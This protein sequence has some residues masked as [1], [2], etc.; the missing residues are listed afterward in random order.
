MKKQIF[1]FAIACILTVFLLV[2]CSGES[3]ADPD[4]P[5][6]IPGDGTSERPGGDTDSDAPTNEVLVT[7][8]SE[9]AQVKDR[10]VNDFDY[11]SLFSILADNENVPVEASYLDLTKLKTSPGSYPVTC[12]YCDKQAT[13]MI[14]VLKTDYRVSLSRE[15]VSVKLS[16]AQDF[17]YPAL[18]SVTMDGEPVSVTSDMVETDFTPAEGTYTYTVTYG[19]ASATLTVRVTPDHL[20]E[21]MTSYRNLTLTVADLLTYDYTDLFSLYRDGMPIEV[22]ADM[23][24]TSALTGE[25]A[26]P[27]VGQTYPVILHYTYG[28]SSCTQTARVTVAAEEETVVTTKNVVIYP[29]SQV[30]DLTT[31]FRITRGDTELP[32]D[33]ENITGTIDYTKGGTY[34]ISLSYEGTDY[35]ATV[36]VRDG[37]V[38]QYAV[39]D[40]VKVKKGTN[41]AT[42]PFDGDFVVI[43]NG[44]RFY[45]IPPSYFDLTEVD[46]TR[47][48]TY[49]ATLSIPYNET[50]SSGI[51]PSVTFTYYTATIH[52]QVVENNYSIA[53]GAEELLLPKGTTSYNVFGNLKV[54]I[55]GRNQTLTGNPAYVDSISCYAEV[56]SDPIDFESLAVQTVRIAVYVD[57]PD[58]DPVVVTYPLRIDSDIRVSAAGAAVFAGSAFY[59]KDLFTITR[60]DEPVEV[61]YDM[62]SGKVDIFTPGVYTVTLEFEGI[63]REAQVVVFDKALIGT[64]HTSL[65]TIAESAADDEEQPS[66]ALPLGD[67]V[68]RADGT[69]T[70]NGSD[71]VITGGIDSTTMTLSY[72][73]YAYTLYFSDGIAVLDP[74][75]SLKLGYNDWKRPMIYFHEDVWEPE[76]K[77]TVNYSSSHVLELNCITYSID[78][79]HI[80][81]TTGEREMWYALKIALVEKTSADTVYKVTWGEASY[82]DGFVPG[83]DVISVLTFD[84]LT[85]GFT[86]SS[87]TVGKVNP[88]DGERLWTNRVFTGTLNGKPAELR[89]D[90]YEHFTFLVDGVTVC[91]VNPTFS[92]DGYAVLDYRNE[93]AL[94]YDMTGDTYEPYAYFFRLNTEENTFTVVEKDLYFGKYICENMYLFLDGYGTG[95]INF[96]TRSY[97]TTSISYRVVDGVLTVRY[98][99]TNPG[100]A[101]GESSSYYI[102]P[103]LN[104]LTVRDFEGADMVGRQF[105]N[106]VIT[107]G[108]IVEIS[109]FSLGQATSE[110]AGLEQLLSRITITTKD[111][112]LNDAAKKACINKK[113]VLFTRAGYYLYTITL[114]VGGKDVVSRYALQVLPA[115]YAG[116]PLAVNWGVGLLGSGNALVIDACGKV[117][118]AVGDS[119]YTGLARLNEDSFT[120]QLFSETHSRLTLQGSLLAEGILQVRGSGDMNFSN[121]FTTGTAKSTGTAGTVLRAITVNG[122]TKYYLS[123]SVSSFGTAVT[124]ECLNGSDPGATGAILCLTDADRHQTC[125]KVNAW[126]NTSEGLTLADA[127]R[128]TYIAEGA[129]DLIL[130]GFGGAVY[131]GGAATYR[132]NG[133]VATVTLSQSDV[134][135]FRLNTADAGYEALEIPVGNALLEGKTFTATYQF[136]CGYY[137]Y[138]A[139]TSFAFGKNGVVTVT[140]VSDQHDNG[141]DRCEDDL[142]APTFATNA[143]TNGTYTVSGDHVTVTV[144]GET[145]VFLISNLQICNQIVCESTTVSSDAH[146]YFKTG[147]AFNQPV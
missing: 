12:T 110:T 93:T 64:Y 71:A 107:D 65:T 102:P 15:E 91:Y 143:G 10:Q 94:L 108:A 142:Y 7:A 38:L 141:D 104:V 28:T 111:G 50:A 125:L 144:G 18:F 76:E 117:T 5:A 27:T 9:S 129:P 37:V 105:V 116:H 55:N 72:G 119:H 57:G 35:T 48:G 40:T 126:S 81:S 68:I 29:N 140:S 82:P 24:D 19:D 147:T 83:K 54:T 132:M 112:V 34:D 46:F 95:C 23:L 6:G 45:D 146:G 49:D 128:G 36:E 4:D 130:D 75:N 43:I 86:M 101:Y 53:L 69:V 22:T 66:P 122:V 109:S 26:Q 96:N 134:R 139:D 89:T 85:Y 8:L 79:F 138:A 100:F 145:F 3:P 13:V 99:N 58:A 52:Y 84:D 59:V 14:Q 31:L 42:Y 120:A 39:S 135:L 137:S 98:L 78:T 80:R 90:Q 33:R 124:A 20:L 113:A 106:S 44:L 77:V 97:S 1:L 87:A 127:Y 136:S 60:G 70:L 73:K 47:A 114:Q 115:L 88:S 32:V 41:L 16:A 62:I 133:T 17:D 51:V 131:D 103:L 11:T 61:T 2:S 118:L 92:S 21:V 67:L 74:D 63:L 121:V 25:E 30:L 56:L 123:A